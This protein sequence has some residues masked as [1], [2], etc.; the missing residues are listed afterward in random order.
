MDYYTIS[1]KLKE[2]IAIAIKSNEDYRT[3]GKSTL[4]DPEYDVLLEEI[5]QLQDKM[6]GIAPGDETLDFNPRQV[7]AVVSGK[8]KSKLP[9]TMA[10]MNKAK[11]YEDVL[12]WLRLKGIPNDT[13][14]VLTPKYDGISLCVDEETNKAWTRGD[15]TE[16]QSSDGHL[17][18]MGEIFPKPVSIYSFGE[19]IIKRKVFDER[20]SFDAV[21]E[22]KGFANGRNMVAGKFNDDKPN[23]ILVDV[24]YIRYGM[25]YKNKETTSSKVEQL[26]GLNKMNK[27]QVPFVVSTI[28]EMT[29]DFL[30]SLFDK[31]SVE[32]EL[33]GLIIDVNEYDLRDELGRDNDNNPH[34][35]KAYKNNF[36]QKKDTSIIRL[37]RNISKQGFLKPIV[38]VIGVSLDGATVKNVTGINE[39]YLI[40]MGI[41]AG[42]EITVRRSGMVIPQIIAIDG[43]PLP[44][45]S[46]KKAIAEFA[47]TRSHIDVDTP[48]H[49]PCCGTELTWNESNVELMC[50]NHDGCADQL[51]QK[52]I[53]FF[54]ILDVDSVGEGNI[55][56]FFD[57]GYDSVSKI[58]K[59]SQKDME[60]IDRFGKRKADLIYKSIHGKMNGVTLSKLQH[61]SGFFEGLGSKKLELVEG[62]ALDEDALLKISG[63]AKKSVKI[64]LDGLPMYEEFVKELPITIAQKKQASSNELEG[65]IIVFT[66]FRNPEW[67][68]AVEDMGGKLGSSLS[69]KTTILV[70]LDV[71]GNSGKLSKARKY[72]TN[73]MNAK[74]FEAKFGPFAIVP[75]PAAPA[76][77]DEE[78]DAPQDKQLSLF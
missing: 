11:S 10:S 70:A 43:I 54:E 46:D 62:V 45:A 72:G 17:E 44:A 42:E 49:C 78:D 60:S 32:Y 4:S 47:E 66:G 37:Q 27:V 23:V 71:S 25:E 68:A 21:G 16:G 3:L 55:K 29:E 52:A 65:E 9:I 61:A 33:D 63:F 22:D 56:A 75:P 34:F 30:A 6:K 48:T 24:D 13:K 12:D 41:A 15:G 35:A 59:M 1:N 64:Y 67:E 73:L 39:R 28:D 76:D 77:P 20:Y 31:W 5:E 2:K 18:K 50:T 40:N 69:K 74:D 19:A 51:L 8:R 14:F 58:L 26:E 36:E 57:A 38:E 53:S 7:G